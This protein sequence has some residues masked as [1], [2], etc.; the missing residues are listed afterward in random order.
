MLQRRPQYGHSKKDCRFLRQSFFCRK[1][2]VAPYARHQGLSPTGC[3]AVLFSKKE[4][5]KKAPPAVRRGFCGSTGAGQGRMR[6]KRRGGKRVHSACAG[7]SSASK[8]PAA[9]SKSCGME[10]MA[11]CSVSGRL[12][13]HSSHS[14]VSSERAPSSTILSPKRT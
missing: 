8:I 5:K 3:K 11:S 10:L 9:S 13:N 6:R 4:E 12:L 1:Q 14:K 7:W 2:S